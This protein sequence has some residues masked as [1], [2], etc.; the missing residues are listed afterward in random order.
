MQQHERFSKVGGNYMN[1]TRTA[2]NYFESH[3]RRNSPHDQEF[4]H[5]FIQ[6]LEEAM[7]KLKEQGG[8]INLEEDDIDNLDDN[9]LY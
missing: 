6:Y 1:A 5:C 4:F 3:S 8:D 7:K 9:I 2:K